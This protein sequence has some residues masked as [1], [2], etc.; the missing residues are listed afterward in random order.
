MLNKVQQAF[1]TLLRSGLWES[2]ID[3]LSI[4]PL[5]KEEWKNLYSISM[6]QTVEGIVYEG[7][8]KLP[9]AFLP[10]K[11][12]QLRWTVRVDQIER[13]NKLMAEILVQIDD[14]FKEE[15][16][17]FTLLKG[18][19]L[20]S[21]YEKPLL[22]SS[23]DIDLYFDSVKDF[24]RANALIRSKNIQ[25]NTGALNSSIYLWKSCEV[26]HHTKMMDILNPFKQ[27]YIKKL[28]N[29]EKGFY[30][31]LKIQE[32]TINGISWTLAHIQTNS[33][34]LKHYL[35]FG[36]GLRQFC[37]VA[38]LYKNSISEIDK[39]KLQAHYKKLGILDWM[40]MV[41]NLL[42]QYL[43]LSKNF[44]PFENHPEQDAKWLLNDVLVAGNFGF[45]DT[46]YVQHSDNLKENRQRNNA[47]ERV[48][49][50]LLNAKKYA[51][52]EAFWFPIFK[53]RD[54]LIGHKE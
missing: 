20:A 15:D 21:L 43:G 13:Q 31:K 49:P 19:S 14:I 39:L 32:K 54:R 25:V 16:I 17:P 12:F 50:H 41:N 11:I 5:D 40:Y 22:R 8:L 1:L 4:F 45:H 53:T 29:A 42:I 51:P 47:L 30:R 48:V 37:D 3:D 26:E 44:L 36:I 35:G 6:A 46:R 7:M 23:G 28:I 33:H 52:A 24:K 2:P 9:P 10:H 38:R 27:G 34:I 18:L